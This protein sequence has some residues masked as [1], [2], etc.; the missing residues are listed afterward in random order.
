LT[1]TGDDNGLQRAE[2]NLGD[3]C[4][5]AYRD[6]SDADIAFVNGGAIR[7]SLEPGDI[8]YGQILTE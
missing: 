4:E 5:D 7:V 2:T 3:L 8:T 6:Q 1:T